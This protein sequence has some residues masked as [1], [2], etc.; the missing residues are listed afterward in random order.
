MLHHCACRTVTSSKSQ[1]ASKHLFKAG[2][3]N[4]TYWL[5][6]RQ[7]N[8]SWHSTLYVSEHWHK[9][10]RYAVLLTIGNNS[11]MCKRSALL[12][13]TKFSLLPLFWVKCCYFL[14][15][16]LTVL[17]TWESLFPLIIRLALSLIKHGVLKHYTLF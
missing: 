13:N 10:A 5:H 8:K 14:A 3:H 16:T 4:A 11:Y 9:M 7:S 6:S 17:S 15:L 1:C 12:Q 2:I